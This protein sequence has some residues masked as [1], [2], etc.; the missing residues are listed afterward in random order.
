[1]SAVRECVPLSE[2][3]CVNVCVVPKRAV[4]VGGLFGGLQVQCHTHQPLRNSGATCGHEQDG[5]IDIQR[6]QVTSP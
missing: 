1:M 6:Q 5:Q 2:L 3:V 4:C